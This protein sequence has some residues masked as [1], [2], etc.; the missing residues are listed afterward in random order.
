MLGHATARQN[1]AKNVS[2][3]KRWGIGVGGKVTSPRHGPWQAPFSLWA[4]N[5]SFLPYREVGDLRNQNALAQG[6]EACDYYHREKVPGHRELGGG[7]YRQMDR[8]G[9]ER[10]LALQERVSVPRGPW[11]SKSSQHKDLQ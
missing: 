3:A 2:T 4:N 7:V 10:C 9:K 1:L 5:S 6:R 11:H 8:N